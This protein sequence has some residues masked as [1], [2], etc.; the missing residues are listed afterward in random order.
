M[1]FLEVIDSNRGGLIVAFNRINGFVPNSHIPELQN[2][3]SYNKVLAYKEEKIGLKIPVRIIEIDRDNNRLIFSVKAA[4]R[5][6]RRKRL[7]ELNPGEVVKGKVVNIVNYGVFVELNG[8]TGLIHISELDWLR[9]RHP[10]EVIELGEEIEVLIKDVDLDNERVRLSRRDLLPDPWETFEDH[11][12]NGDIVEGVVTGLKEYGV[13]IR[14]PNNLEGLIHISEMNGN[15]I[16]ALSI[17]ETI[18]VRIVAIDSL[19]ERISLSLKGVIQEGQ[20]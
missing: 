13:F 14:L 9:V 18:S 17:G 2:F 15:T 10:S 1:H 6:I 12:Y 4:Q 8:I 7:R 5:E 11:F 16:N 3:N 19:R 20:H